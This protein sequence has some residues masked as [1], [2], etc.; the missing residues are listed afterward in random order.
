M[1]INGKILNM[2]VDTGAA[3]S[4]ILQI[5]CQKLL[6]KV[7]LR[8]GSLHLCTYTGEPIGVEGELI[9]PVKYGS[10]TKELGLIVIQGDDPSLFGRNW[11]D[12][13][14]LYRKYIG[15]AM[16]DGG[17][18]KVNALL[19]RY[20]EVFTLGLRTMKHFEAKLQV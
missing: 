18:A 20:K 10:Q 14:Q 1:E 15:L 16:L 11:L 8:P 5:T 17:Q 7:P 6:S 4:I 19:K 3:V 12:L 2:E 13:F 9:T